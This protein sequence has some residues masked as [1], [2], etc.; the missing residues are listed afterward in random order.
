MGTPA[1]I[2]IG[3]L[4]A[5]GALAGIGVAAMAMMHFSM[6]GGWGC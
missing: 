3:V 4:A 2:A 1:K 6:M 5:I